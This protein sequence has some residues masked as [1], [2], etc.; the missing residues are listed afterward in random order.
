MNTILLQDSSATYSYWVSLVPC[1][2]VG[3]DRNEKHMIFFRVWILRALP[4]GI[5][6]YLKNIDRCPIE[7]IKGIDDLLAQSP[8]PKRCDRVSW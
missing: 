3:S 7:A 6:T 5:Q 4:T 1:C 2:A 8:V